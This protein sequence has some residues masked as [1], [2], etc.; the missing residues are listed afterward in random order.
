VWSRDGRFVFATSVLRGEH[1]VLFSSVI[2][3]DL[4]AATPIAR[5]LRDRAGA[6]ARLTPAITAAALDAAALDAAPEYLP[7]LARI[8]A[9]ALEERDRLPDAPGRKLD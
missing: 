2:Y 5:M 1:S 4:R 7:E 3:V 6:A 9:G 8:V